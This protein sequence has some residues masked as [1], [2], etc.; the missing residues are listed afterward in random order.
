MKRTVW[1][2]AAIGAAAWIALGYEDAGRFLFEQETFEGNGRT[3]LTCHGK[4]T[5]TISP[6]DAQR[7]FALNPR[8]PLFRHDGS[9]DGRGNGVNRM[10]TEATILVEIPLPANVRLA[11]DRYA[12]T[13]TL[14]RGIASTLNTPALDRVL[15][16]DGR[17]PSLTSQARNA[18]RGHAQAKI[19][20]TPGQLEAIARF[21]RGGSFFSSFAMRAFAEGG[22]EPA[23]PAGVTEPEKRGRRFFEDVFDPND[24]RPGACA[25]CHSGPMLNQTNRFFAPPLGGRFQNVG[26]SEFNRAGNPVRTFIFRN[27]DGSEQTVASPDP[28]LALITGQARDANTFKIPSLRGLRKTAP[29]FHD[30]SARTL[31]DVAEHYAR[32]FEVLI[33]GKPVVLTAQ[34]KA[35]MAAYMRLLE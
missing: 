25:L 16:A 30:N 18:I 10:L 32:L 27:A 14:R 21:E 7:R 4:D 19:E 28:G 8:D 20:P 33:P 15:M 3:C 1:I 13:V 34:E 2:A 29:Y 35:D 17:E 23:L 6:Q 26:V 9:D 22:P 5:G 12:R 11:D 31:E 24:L